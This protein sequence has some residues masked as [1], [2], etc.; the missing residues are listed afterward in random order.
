MCQYII[1]TPVLN[2]RWEIVCNP[3]TV[4]ATVRVRMPPF[5][6]NEFDARGESNVESII[7]PIG[8]WYYTCTI[9][10]TTSST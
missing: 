9:K 7:L 5:I 2:A 4:P 6:G 10:N 3:L 1:V 8:F